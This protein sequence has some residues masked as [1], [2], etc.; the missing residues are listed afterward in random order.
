MLLAD[1]APGKLCLIESIDFSCCGRQREASYSIFILTL[2]CFTLQAGKCGGLLHD[3]VA[4]VWLTP[5]EQQQTWRSAAAADAAAED[6]GA[7]ECL[8][9]LFPS[10][11][12]ALGGGG[13]AAQHW[14]RRGAL[15]L[16]VVTATG[17]LTVLFRPCPQLQGI[18]RLQCGVTERLNA[19]L[20]IRGPC[21]SQGADASA[22][23]R[24]HGIA[25]LCSANLSLHPAMV[26]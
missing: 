21:P 16:A 8:E 1:L 2:C 23:A 3:A 5:P 9:S 6:E 19:R 15:V 12:R 4:A 10:G 11:P 7:V 26:V 20:P 25:I 18:L 13:A 17:H 24:V 22:L 14:V